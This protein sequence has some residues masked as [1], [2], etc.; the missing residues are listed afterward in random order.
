MASKRCYYEVLEV[1]READDD[2]IKSSYR[3]LAMQWHPDRNPGDGDAE[4]KFKE[5]AE[6]Y[7]VLR[8]P[9][10]RER[11]NRYGHAGLEG[12]NLPNFGN[13]DSVMDLFG[14]LLGGVFGGGRGRRGPQAGRDLQTPVELD[15]VEAYKGVTRKVTIP[16]AEPCSDCGGDGCKKG[17]RPVSCRRCNGQGVVIQGQGFFRIQQ[18]CP[19]CGGRGAIITD[20]CQ[21]CRGAGRVVRD[22]E[23]S[24]PIPQGIEHG[25]DIRI[26]GEGE[27]GG[28]GAPPGDLYIRVR[29]KKHPLFDRD[30][31]NLHCVVPVT[32]SQAA[33]GGPIEVPTL[34]GKY[35][36]HNLKRGTQAGDEVRLAGK[37]MPTLPRTHG[38]SGRQGDLILHVRLVTP[39]NLTKRQEELLRELGEI[40]GKHVS[41]ERKS[42]LDRVRDFFTPETSSANTAK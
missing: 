13:A 8:D 14:E 22:R 37:G 21:A 23:V 36:S 34:E 7:E 41:P 33:L 6:A 9:E 39:R 3:R 26:S 40:E 29:V 28:P 27:A 15:L 30:G 19:G 25:H 24:V 4:I 12:M 32:F 10:K 31:H 2:T 20:P 42:F 18:T 38:G 35:V 5:A 1:V 11:Y 16:R 17:T